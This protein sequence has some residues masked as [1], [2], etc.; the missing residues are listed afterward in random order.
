MHTV[1]CNLALRVNGLCLASLLHSGQLIIISHASMVLHSHIYSYLRQWH[2]VL[3]DTGDVNYIK[4]ATSYT[5]HLQTH[6]AALIA[7]QTY[8]AIKKRSAVI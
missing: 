8:F 6:G 2:R 7:A 4:S 3:L 5:M 1:F